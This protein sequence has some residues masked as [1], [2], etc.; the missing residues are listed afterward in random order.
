MRITKAFL[1]LL[2]LCL[3]SCAPDKKQQEAVVQKPNI[4]FVFADDMAFT[5]LDELEQ[6]EIFTPNLDK[7]MAEGT[8]FTKAYNMG[9]WS[10]AV[11]TASRSMMISG[12]SVWN[13]FDLKEEWRKGDKTDLTLPKL[14]EE[15]GYETYMSGKWHVDIPPP[16]IFNHTIHIR[17][18]MPKDTWS[19]NNTGAKFDSINK[20]GADPASIMPLG[21][22][23]P[24]IDQQDDW[25]PSDRSLGGF[26]EGGTHW[27]EVL[28]ED[29]KSFL[30]SAS[31]S[32][33]PFFM[34]LAFNA[35]H[36]PRQSPGSFLDLYVAEDLKIPESFM[37]LYP[38]KDEIGNGPGLR[39]EA[40]APFPRTPFAIKKHL[41][42]YY[43]IVSHMDYQIGKIFEELE[44]KGLREN[45]YIIF[46]ADHGLAMGNHGLMGKQTMFDHSMGAP[47]IVS[48]PNIP[49]GK[50]LDH[51]IYIQDAMAT[52]LEIAGVDKPDYV[53]FESLLDLI[54]GDQ[55]LIR[56]EVYGAYLNNQRMIKKDGFKLIVYPNAKKL[57]LFDMEKD[58]LEI[59]DLSDQP[60]YKELKRS[61]FTALQQLQG[62]LNDKLELNKL[63]YA[64]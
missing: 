43:A 5:L 58:P 30:D 27:S 21:Y 51:D 47:F 39:D 56:E 22:N 46:T 48:G 10:G 28:R 8:S 63:D 31:K 16:E 14:L 52:I 53:E 41:Q 19:K 64:F 45:T 60:Q 54:N 29:A 15:S 40:L 50:R 32:S 4:L 18:G 9:S 59:K 57:L 35:V 13:A 36:D 26:W 42:E 55:E 24:L 1:F 11:C 2:S 7:L 12:R 20:I 44:R 33:N 3:F 6:N 34:Y 61:L 17:A 25:S 38:Y 49:K 37:P 23:R 62:R